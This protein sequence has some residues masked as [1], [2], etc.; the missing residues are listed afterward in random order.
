MNDTFKNKK[1]SIGD[2]LF[3]YARRSHEFASQIDIEKLFE[4]GKRFIGCEVYTVRELGEGATLAWCAKYNGKLLN[5]YKVVDVV[6]VSQCC[7]YQPSTGNSSWVAP[8]ITFKVHWF[9]EDK[10]RWIE[11]VN[12]Y[13]SYEL[14]DSMEKVKMFLARSKNFSDSF[15]CREANICLDN[16]STLFNQ[17]DSMRSWFCDNAELIGADKQEYLDALR[18]IVEMAQSSIDKMKSDISQ[19]EKKGNGKK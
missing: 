15:F 17:F 8:C 2:Y 18:K 10:K 1:Y 3:K 9:S 6:G 11:S 4:Y 5:K 16:I 7:A 13:N 12:N 19:E 14:F